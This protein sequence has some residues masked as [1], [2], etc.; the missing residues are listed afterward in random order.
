MKHRFC[1]LFFAGLLSFYPLLAQREADNWYFGQSAGL[2]FGTNPPQALLTGGTISEE[3]SATI[4]DAQGRLLFYSN[5]TSILNRAHQG[6]KN[7][8]GLAG[9]QSSTQGVIII[10]QPGNDSMYYVFTN[11][12]VHQLLENGLKYSIV[13]MRGDNGL[14]EVIQKNIGLLTET[15]ER[16]AA[17]RHCN[18]QDVWIVIRKWESDQYYAYLLTSS[19]LN[20]T[21]VISSTGNVVSGDLNN[22]I[23]ALKFSSKGNKLA[24]AFGYGF[25]KVELMDFNRQNGR[26][27]NPIMFR[28]NPGSPVS[29]FPG[30]YGLEFSPNSRYLYANTFNDV[31][32]SRLYQFDIA[33]QNPSAIENS[34]QLIHT[35]TSGSGAGNMQIATDKKIYVA[36]RGKSALSV[37]TQPDNPGTGSAFV[38]DAVSLDPLGLRRTLAG[39]PN[40]IQSYFDDESSNY[41]FY[42]TGNCTD[43]TVAFSMSQTRGFDSLRWDFGDGFVSTAVDPTHTFTSAGFHDIRLTIFKVTCSGN[44]QVINKRIWIA[45]TSDFLEPSKSFCPPGSVILNSSISEVGF[46]WST[47]SLEA[48]IEVDQPGIYWLEVDG[49]GCIMRDS[50]QVTVKPPL[51]ID[52]GKD[53]SVCTLQPVTLDAGISGVSY[54]W[55]TGDTT[56]TLL[57]KKPG[58]F[59]LQVSSTDGCS[60]ADSVLV[61]PGD[62]GLF[63]PGAFTPNGDGLNDRFGPVDFIQAGGYEFSIF[64]R[65]GQIIFRT[66]DAGEKWDGNYKGK[67][68]PA[69]MYVWIMRYQQRTY[70]PQT[71][72]GTVVL[73]R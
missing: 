7:G 46:H 68:A 66:N 43:R 35:E 25:D 67:P 61:T 21:P 60:A 27:T 48:G 69:G 3:G 41:D 24:C 62:C 65:Y 31:F 49:Y 17:I 6:M 11:G 10:P 16:I 30:T 34:R 36:Y 52:L 42:R 28:A 72:R 12:A 26:L 50:T 29:G 73:F 57:V 64:N 63:L 18:N 22:N 44:S 51:T 23:G 15:Y 4:S 58:L 53:T 55:N 54:L 20:S 32:E 9:D 56:R 19:G 39:L 38:P 47:G 45:E 33:V 5:G 59:I 71:I 2:G 40:F 70:L 1:I 14:G 13:N 8:T 37:I